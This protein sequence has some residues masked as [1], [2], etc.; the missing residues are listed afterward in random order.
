MLKLVS[1]IIPSYNRR[2]DLCRCI[3]SDLQQQFEQIEILVVDDCSD[4]DTIDY[5]NLNYPDVRLTSCPRRYGPSHLRNL[6]LREAQGEF[7]LFLNSDVILPKQA[8]VERMV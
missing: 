6:G 4:D 8:I 2:H 7:I 5:V 3:D 1:V